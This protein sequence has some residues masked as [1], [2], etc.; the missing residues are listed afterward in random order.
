M[1]NKPTIV[2]RYGLH[3]SHQNITHLT[4]ITRLKN[5]E[6]FECRLGDGAK[7]VK[8]TCLKQR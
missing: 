6:N 7:Y 8:K 3:T 2:N 4:V 1:L 5:M